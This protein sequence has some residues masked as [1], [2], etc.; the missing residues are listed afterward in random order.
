MILQVVTGVEK[1]ASTKRRALFTAQVVVSDG[2][3]EVVLLLSSVLVLVT[4]MYMTLTK[5]EPKPQG[6][7]RILPSWAWKITDVTKTSICI[8][9]T[10]GQPIF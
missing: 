5:S 9:G 3:L 2:Y 10:R 1:P 7:A 8:I 4:Y 6:K